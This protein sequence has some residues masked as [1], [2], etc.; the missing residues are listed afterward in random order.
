[1]QLRYW[2]CGAIRMLNK[3]CIYIT[4]YVVQLGCLIKNAVTLL[5]MWCS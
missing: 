5:V 3:E 4:G 1:M 2:L